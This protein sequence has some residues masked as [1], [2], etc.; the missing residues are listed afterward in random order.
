MTTA[1]R[2]TTARKAMRAATVFTGAAAMGVAFGPGAALAAAGHAPAQDHPAQATGT[3]PA[4]I[5]LTAADIESRGCT[6]NTWL[7]IE[8]SSV[9]RS[10][11]RQYGYSG[12]KN[13]FG[14]YMTA[15][16]GGNNYGNILFANGNGILFGP[17]RTYRSISGFISYV[18]IV[19][20]KGADKCAWPR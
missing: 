19:S 7:H 15:Q 11:C 2:T 4:H 10:L 5:R 17:G 13:T 16:C 6:T 1:A 9:V 20:W 14:M 18:T 12:S 8:Y 3:T